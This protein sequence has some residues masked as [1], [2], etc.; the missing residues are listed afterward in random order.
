MGMWGMRRW[1]FFAF[2][3]I[4]KL[5]EIDLFAEFLKKYAIRKTR[6]L[7]DYINLIRYATSFTRL[8][9][10]NFFKENLRKDFQPSKVK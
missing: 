5:A 9:S 3:V 7:Y 2:G 1:E 8:K 6:C 4:G 10:V